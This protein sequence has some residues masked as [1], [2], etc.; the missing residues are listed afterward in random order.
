MNSVDIEKTEDIR[1]LWLFYGVAGLIYYIDYS[2]DY[3]RGNWEISQ[4][5]SKNTIFVL[6][7]MCI[8]IFNNHV[9]VTKYFFE[10]RYFIY[11]GSVLILILVACLVE[12]LLLEKWLYPDSRGMNTFNLVSF[13][14]YLGEILSGFFAF[15]C[16]K[17]VFD[18]FKKERVISTVKQ[19]KLES[20]L[21]F[22]KSQIQPHI[23]FNSLNS[24][25]DA[26][27]IQSSKTPEMILKLSNLLRYIL[28]DSDREYVDLSKELAI[29]SD[30]VDLQ[31][32]QLEGRGEVA[33]T[34]TYENDVRDKIIAPH[35]IIP[36]I[37]N[38]FKHSL[39]SKVTDILITIE[40]V[41]SEKKLMLK[42]KNTYD[43]RGYD[44]T[45]L[46]T[47]GIGIK[48]VRRRMELLYPDKHKLKVSNVGNSY[49]VHLEL[50]L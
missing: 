13:Y 38:G 44:T 43:P 48:N 4:S 41:I 24:I 46:Q 49:L 6:F 18:N 23:L 30:Y 29:L 37:E 36:F 16:I 7:H 35:L 3:F 45:K 26:S 27:R 34:I 33:Y 28:Y 17:V 2:L 39:S 15:T 10:K 5:V 40:L 31:K 14:H 1:K 50:E 21:R 8:F 32:L 20:D 47:K 11:L 22:L 19:D 42:V 25:Y 9:L 12:E